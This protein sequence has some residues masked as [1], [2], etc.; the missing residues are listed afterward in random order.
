MRGNHL[1][2]AATQG[3]RFEINQL[4]FADDTALVSDSEEKLCSL[5]SEFGRVCKSRKLRVN[6]SKSKVMRCSRYGNWGSVACE[7]KWRAVRQ[8]GLSWTPGVASGDV[9]TMNEGY[10]AWGALKCVLNDRGLGINGKKCLYEGVIV[11]N[12]LYRA[13]AWG[14]SSA[15]SR[16]VNILEMKC[17]RSLFGVS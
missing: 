8:S 17:L 16:K 14:M 10:R 15:E 5:M 1:A 6:V 4:L 12:A 13:E 2:Y 7:T 11:P 3:V 9:V